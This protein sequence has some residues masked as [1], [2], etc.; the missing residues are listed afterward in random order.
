MLADDRDTVDGDERLDLGGGTA[1]D[2]CD[3][4]IPRRETRQL[5]PRPV[6]HPR[7]L[8]SLDD[9][10][11]HSVDVEH[12]GGSTGLGGEASKQLVGGRL[13]RARI[14]GVWREGV[15]VALRLVLVGLV[16]G[17]FSTVFGVGGGIVVVP[18][19]VALLAFP[20]HAAAATSLGAILVT[21]T[22]GVALYAL[23]GEVRAGVR[24]ARRDPRRRRRVRRH[25][26]PA[27]CLEPSADAE[28]SRGCSRS[29]QSGCSSHERL[30]DRRR[31]LA[32]GLGA[33]VLSGIFGVGGGILFVPTLVALGLGQVEASA[34]SLLAIVPTAAVGALRQRS[35]GNLRLRPRP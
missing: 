17:V 2:A 25:L 14:R 3:E 1:A 23:R 20:A 34:T 18:L 6:R 7:V 4:A 11:E 19:L 28:R 35:Y 24:S 32:L 21:A 15:P 13:H 12:Y 26:A 22:A 9:R 5:V 16:A 30:D 31:D 8:G 10:G 29:P 27:T 33:G